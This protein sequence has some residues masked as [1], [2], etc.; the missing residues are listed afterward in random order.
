[1]IWILLKDNFLSIQKEKG[2]EVE[3]F[4]Y[5]FLG[6]EITNENHCPKNLN[7]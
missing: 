6:I 1:M 2:K 4:N 3:D 5:T 7:Y